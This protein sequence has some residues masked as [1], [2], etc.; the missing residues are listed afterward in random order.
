MKRPSHYPLH[1][2]NLGAGVQSTALYLLFMTGKIQPLDYAIFAD[3]GEE[4]QAVYA[5]LQYLKS[6]GGPEILVRS[7]GKL[8]DDLSR[9]VNSTG[10]RFASIP[11][12]TGKDGKPC[13]M[14]RRQCSKEYKT[15]VIDRAIRREILGMKPRQRVPKG[16]TVTQY[17]GISADEAGRARRIAD[18]FAAQTKWA[19]PRFPL[20]E[21]N[22]TRADCL[23]FLTSRVPHQTPRS[24][25]VFCPYHSDAE[26]LHI[27]NGGGLDWDRALEIDDTLRVPGNILNRNL[28]Q[29]LFLHRSRRPLRDVEFDATRDPREAQLSMSFW[30]ECEGVCGI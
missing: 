21:R 6:L 13:G 15:A 8:G 1:I 19:M 26:W 23:R 4:P 7:K 17:F 27:R 11:A 5:H 3:T 30:A 9:G 24:A 14:L 29:Q 22:A 2:L 12:F 20:L 10:Q 28:Q 25:C 16:I 18:H